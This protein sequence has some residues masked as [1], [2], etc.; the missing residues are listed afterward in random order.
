MWNWVSFAL[1]TAAISTTLSP[2]EPGGNHFGC[3]AFQS[4]LVTCIAGFSPA[5][6]WMKMA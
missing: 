5:A 4:Q 3:C 2:V 6:S 1:A